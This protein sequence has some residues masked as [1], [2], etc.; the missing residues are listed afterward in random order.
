M[1]IAACSYAAA[2]ASDAPCLVSRSAEFVL[3]AS[4]AVQRHTLS[5]ITTQNS[6]D[7]Q[8][9]CKASVQVNSGTLQNSSF[10]IHNL[11]F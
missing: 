10:L 4:R 2:A 6:S 5:S 7:P 8:R 1:G 11:S 3:K 9:R